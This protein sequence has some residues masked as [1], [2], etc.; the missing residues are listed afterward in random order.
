MKVLAL[1]LIFVLLLETLP[2]PASAAARMS[3]ILKFNGVPTTMAP[4]IKKKFPFVF[5]REVTLAEVDEVVRYLYHTGN[6]S[7]VEAVERDT[8][9]GVR[10]LAIVAS[11][12]RRVQK[13]NIKGNHAIGSSDVTKTLGLEQGQIF[14][15]K[16]LLSAAEELRKIYENMGYHNV[17]VEIDFDLPNESEVA[18]NVTIDEGSP[19]RI[20]SAV[21][22]SGNPDLN[23]ALAHFAFWLKGKI[24]T[25][26]ELLDFQRRVN[27][28]LAAHHYLTARLSTPAIS[29]T[30]DRMKAKLTYV[31]DNPW[32]FRFTYEGNIYFADWTLTQ[33]LEADRVAGVTTSLAPSLAEKIRRRYLE[34]GFANADVKYEEKLDEASH[35][36]VINFFVKE[37]HRVRLEK[38]QVSGNISR[39]ESYYAKFIKTST[40]DLIGQGYFSRKDFEDGTKQ[41]ITELQNQGYFRAR[42]QSSRIEFNKDKS[43]VTIFLEIDEG[44]LTQIRQI[45]FDGVESFP[46]A[47]LLEILKIRTGAALGLREL[48]ESI[49]QLK[50]FYHSE[51]FLEMR[52]ANEGEQNRIVSYNEGN[53]QATINF[54]IY[55]GPRVRVGSIQVQGNQLTK[56]NVIMREL[57]FKTGDVLTAEKIENTI[58]H[59]QKLD[60][61]TNVN[62]RTLEEGTNISERTVIITVTEGNPGDVRLRIGAT[63]ER[64]FLTLRGM[65]SGSYRNIYGTGRGVSLRVEPKYSFDPLVSYVENTIT[66]SYLEPFIFGDRNR[67]RVNL[68]RQ[69]ALFSIDPDPTDPTGQ[70][71]L[72]TIQDAITLGFLLERDLTKEV[73]MSYNVYSLSNQRQFVRQT[74]KPKSNLNIAKTGPNF[75]YD[76]R[77]DRF[78]PSRGINAYINLEY[79]DPVMGSS[80]DQSQTINFV[81]TSAMYTQ[82]FPLFKRKDFV[83]IGQLRG[84]YLANISS[85]PLAGVPVQE[86]FFLGGRTTVRGFSGDITDTI[87]NRFDLSPN[88]NSVSQLSDLTAF[89]IKADSYFGLVKAQLNFPTF[90]NSV[91]GT[92][93]YDGGLVAINQPDVKIPVPYRHSV[94]LGIRIVTPVGPVNIEYGWK[95]NR[96]ILRT[97][98]Q[99]PDGYDIVEPAGAFHLSIGEL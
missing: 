36:T 39:P 68:I 53:T 73:R 47:Q 97:A 31:I 35:E 50:S 38:I 8:E 54:Q 77:D 40:S 18:V 19:V 11:V 74:G 51:G 24:L 60:L 13:I 5:E 7:N 42:I 14:E 93:F 86:A 80:K 91:G 63:N 41:L 67:G 99:N 69:E 33:L 58:F 6:F 87:P 28:Y 65:A 27:E 15:R 4:Q 82:Y 16:H 81:K 90:I 46:K 96:R 20:S 66:L 29:Y 92:L 3:R 23:D 55:E 25:E 26:D 2:G 1:S 44:P 52:I 89:R 48:D 98:A 78:L 76:S 79:S 61:F 70:S 21:I 9:S 43:A 57:T 71:K 75:A 37:G 32:K 30:P 64:N 34:V 85:D 17:R 72:A 56:D 45:R 62:I 49:A 88:A 12:L 59:L 95:L 83:F 10:E 84:G 94:G 22:D